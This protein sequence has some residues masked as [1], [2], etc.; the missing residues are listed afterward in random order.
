MINEEQA[1][2]LVLHRCET[3]SQDGERFAVQS[4]ALSGN[5]DY[6][7]V[8][9]NSEDFV[10]R[11][12]HE[13]CYVGGNAHLVNTASG[14]IETVGSAQSVEQYLEDKYD[15]I[16]A[17]DKHYV[18]EPNFGRDDK[19]TTILLRQKLD[20]SLQ[21]AIEFLSPVSRCWLTGKKSTL[22]KAQDMLARE[23]ISTSIQ[24]QAEP[25]SALQIDDSVWYWEALK[26][27]LNRHGIK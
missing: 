1:K 7:I 12:I 3:F 24:L 4:C 11:G 8:R 17:G 18:L 15:L 16:Q 26:A 19:A 10:L 5:G 23:G 25:G 20:C 14:D 21:R 2:A 27:L 22:R 13:R 6:W 9:A